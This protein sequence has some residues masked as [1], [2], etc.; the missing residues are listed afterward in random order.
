[1]TTLNYQAILWISRCLKYKRWLS[2]QIFCFKICPLNMISWYNVYPIEFYKFHM[3]LFFDKVN[4]KYWYS[5]KLMVIFKQEGV[6]DILVQ[7]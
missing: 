6:P 2:T 3:K 5:Q 4:M 7:F 1:L